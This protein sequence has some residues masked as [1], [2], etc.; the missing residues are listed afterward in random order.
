MGQGSAEGTVSGYVPD[1]TG[2]CSSSLGGINIFFLLHVVQINSGAHSAM[3]T[4][5]L[6]QRVQIGLGVKLTTHQQLQR[7]RRR[8]SIHPHS[9]QLFKHRDTFTF[10]FLRITLTVNTTTN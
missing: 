10:D 6:F 9:A 4:G 2:E 7:S 5:G 1:D 3:G 8:E